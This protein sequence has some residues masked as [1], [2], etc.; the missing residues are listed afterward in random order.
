MSR[1]YSPAFMS[2]GL[3]FGLLV[4]AGCQ[5]DTSEPVAEAKKFEVADEPSTDLGATTDPGP[6]TDPAPATDPAATDPAPKTDPGPTTVPGP[7]TDPAAPSDPGPTTDPGPAPKRDPGPGTPSKTAPPAKTSS[8]GSDPPKTPGAVRPPVAPPGNAGPPE[9]LDIEKFK[10]AENFTPKQLVAHL[11]ALGKVQPTSTSQ[12]GR[13]VEAQA[14]LRGRILASEKLM[15]SSESSVEQKLLGVRVK[16]DSLNTLNQLGLP[17][18]LEHLKQFVRALKDHPIPELASKGRVLYLAVAT[19]DLAS[20]NGTDPKWVAEEVL[21]VLKDEPKSIEMLQ[22][23]QEASV[24]LMQMGFEEDGRR[25]ADAVIKRFEG[26]EDEN[27]SKTIGNFKE[28]LALSSF[29]LGEKI[30]AA[31][32]NKSA[33]ADVVKA[34]TAIS[35]LENRGMPTLQLLAQAAQYMEFAGHYKE[36]GQLNDL[37]DVSFGSSK[38]K[39]LQSLMKEA[40]GSAKKRLALIGKPLP[41]S[42]EKVSGGELKWS[43]YEGKVV[44]I[45]FW[46]SWCQPCLEEMPNIKANYDKYKSKGF[47]VIGY[48][49]DKDPKA[50]AAFFENQKLPWPSVLGKDAKK[51]GFGIDEFANSLGIDGIPFVVLIGRDG[52]VADIHVRGPKLGENLEKLLGDKKAGPAEKKPAEKKPEEKKPAE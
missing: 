30:H 50:L 31:M 36:A 15:N 46:A 43:D 25:C 12:Q 20:P 51:R 23:T 49:L 48:N 1:R 37:M 16:I 27:I 39:R 47:E 21:A 10:P 28:G 26:D 34:A 11:E 7:T 32:T 40:I 17:N 9:T 8:G 13:Y 3:L 42:G 24:H 29:K 35:K 52:N 18:I 41:I 6:T 14:L 2:C 19:G 5:G 38:E 4:V 33:A 44:L 22:I 45:D